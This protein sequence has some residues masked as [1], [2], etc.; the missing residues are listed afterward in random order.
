MFQ[1]TNDQGR[2][3]NVR[4]VRKGDA[5]GLRDCLTHDD[6]KPLVEFYDATVN[7]ARFGERGQFVSRYYVDTLTGRDGLGRDLRDGGGLSLCGGVPVWTLD[8][9]AA[10]QAVEW[11]AM[12]TDEVTP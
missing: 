2:K 6:D 10:A 12:Q 4:I 5:Y 11:A 7:P 3:F 8:D 1:V 9:E